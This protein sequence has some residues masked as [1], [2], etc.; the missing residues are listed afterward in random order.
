MNVFEQLSSC[1]VSINAKGKWSGE[2]KVYNK[3]ANLAFVEAIELSSK[4]EAQ[5][6]QKNE[7]TGI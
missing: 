3:N 6:K 7:T 2:V 4:L 5:I 1:K